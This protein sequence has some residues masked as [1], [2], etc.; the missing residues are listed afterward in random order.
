MLNRARVFMHAGMNDYFPRVIAEAAA[1]GLPVLGFAD[2]IAPDVI[3]PGCGIRLNTD[4]FIAE[5]EAL[6]RDDDR[7]DMMGNLARS[8]A[9]DRLGKFSSREPI[10]IMLDTLESVGS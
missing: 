7:I 3:P 6:F 9:D 5:I 4:D 10:R 1:C 8:Y 2:A